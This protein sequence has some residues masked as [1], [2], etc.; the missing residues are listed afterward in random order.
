MRAALDVKGSAWGFTPL[1]NRAFPYGDGANKY[2]FELVL[3][4]RFADDDTGARRTSVGMGV[5]F[6]FAF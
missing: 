5:H 6:G 2:F 1:L 4:V 3:P